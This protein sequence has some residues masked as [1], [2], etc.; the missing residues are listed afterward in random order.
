[1]KPKV[2]ELI[3][4]GA[5]QLKNRG[6]PEADAR[7]LMEHLL[8][9]NYTGLFNM[10][11]DEVDQ[12]ICHLY[13]DGIAKRLKRIPL[14]HITS[15]QF[16]WGNRFFVNENV[17]IPR[18]ETELLI[19]M[20]VTYIQKLYGEGRRLI[21][22]LDMCTGSGCI[23]I[24]LVY[25]LSKYKDLELKVT[26]TDLSDKAL[27]VAKINQERILNESIIEFVQSNLFEDISPS[28]YDLIVSN[29]PY[30]TPEE[31]QTL[32]P[33]V[34]DHEPVMAL[35]G[36]DDGLDFYRAIIEEGYMR[37]Q[38]GGM[39]LFEIGHGQ[40]DHVKT[41]LLNKNYEGVGGQ[42]DLQQLERVV[43]GMKPDQP[44]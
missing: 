43:F 17:L 29:P 35:D 18:E 44:D 39:I 11:Q 32:M 12:E 38:K 1:M 23:A 40:M 28:T 3:K 37:L 22:I 25:E 19:E 9:V 26:A 41:L 2:F 21:R 5:D 27:K 16:F 33:E 36:G 34:R 20:G 42:M 6:L 8:D 31:I 24:S 10:Y 4:N 30:I 13:Q 7:L 14:Q 15:E